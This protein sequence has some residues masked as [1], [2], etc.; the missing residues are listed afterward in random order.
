MAHLKLL[1]STIVVMSIM[2]PR[3]FQLFLKTTFRD[4]NSVK[5]QSA[6][7]WNRVHSKPKFSR[8][9]LLKSKEYSQ[10]IQIPQSL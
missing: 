4:M 2:L 3:T 6:K 7:A 10:S 1:K 8:Q 5:L 9:R